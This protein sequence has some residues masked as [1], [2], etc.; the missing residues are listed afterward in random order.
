MGVMYSRREDRVE[1][2]MTINARSFAQNK[3]IQNVESV[4]GNG[5]EETVKKTVLL[6]L[7]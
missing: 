6:K 2:N 5:N 4:Q 1:R 3:K 7:Y